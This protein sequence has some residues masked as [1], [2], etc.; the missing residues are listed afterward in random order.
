[1]RGKLTLVQAD[2]ATAHTKGPHLHLLRLLPYRS[3]VA[4]ILLVPF[5]ARFVQISASSAQLN[6][7]AR[8]DKS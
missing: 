5:G 1:M 4:R 2:H 7:G 6:F 3:T 8:S